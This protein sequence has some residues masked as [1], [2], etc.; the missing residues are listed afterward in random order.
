MC[1]VRLHFYGVSGLSP[2][3]FSGET[4]WTYPTLTLEASPVCPQRLT[5]LKVRPG[6]SVGEVGGRDVLV[7]TDPMGT[8]RVG[9][10]GGP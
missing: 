3:V 5:C 9:P 1:P 7:P 2:R 6:A 10:T 8:T 4:H